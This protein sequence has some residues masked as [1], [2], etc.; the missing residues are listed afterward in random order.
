MPTGEH[1]FTEKMS[2]GFA[3]RS[4]G[5]EHSSDIFETRGA[6]ISHVRMVNPDDYPD[7]RRN[8]VMLIPVVAIS[9]Q[10]KSTVRLEIRRKL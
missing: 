1:C 2:D 9:G 8:L 5:S 7:T 4:E 10:T 3:V 6:A